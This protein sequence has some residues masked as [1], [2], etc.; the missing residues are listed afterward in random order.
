M[1]S[2]D[3]GGSYRWICEQVAGYASGPDPVW[4]WLASGALLAT[5]PDGV[6]VSR[7]GGCSFT[8]AGGTA[9]VQALDLEVSPRDA[10]TIYTTLVDSMQRTRL[11]RSTDDG[12]TFPE[13]LRASPAGRYLTNVTAS[14]DH[15]YLRVV[16]LTTRLSWVLHSPDAGKSWDEFPFTF[17]ANFAFTLGKADPTTP[18]TLYAITTDPSALIR[19]RDAGKTFT[20]VYMAS[21]PIY[22]FAITDSALYVADGRAGLMRADRDA[23]RFDPVPGAPNAGCLA[24]RGDS[25]YACANYQL[26]R[27]VLSVIGPTT[28]MPLL[29]WFDKVQGP[30]DCPAGSP[31]RTN[32]DPQWPALQQRF[33]PSIPDAGV[34]DAP[35]APPHKSSGCATG[36]SYGGG[37]GAALWLALALI[38]LTRKP[39]RRRR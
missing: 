26:D 2:H 31:S 22:A 1:I 21:G 37:T 13:E 14:G 33:S 27:Q 19:S 30:V 8:P 15:L 9:G 17:P 5:T 29:E 23:T 38:A 28:S 4:R 35:P 34:P 36:G 20:A 25:A 24:A 32:C 16:E 6:E 18:E 12:A 39:F 3:G 11:L 7:D 10:R